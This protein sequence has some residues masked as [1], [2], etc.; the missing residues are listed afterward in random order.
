M[1][2]AMVRL[3]AS[4]AEQAGQTSALENA[5]L[6]AKTINELPFEL[7]LWQAQNIW[8]D[9]WR[10][11]HQTIYAEP[12]AWAEGF[13]ELGKLLRFSVEELAIDETLN[14]PA[15]MEEAPA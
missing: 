11:Q 6:A 7:N 3:Q 1:K 15:A 2:G 12:V 4:L 5:L 10:Q 9:L 8:Y 14:A 13:T